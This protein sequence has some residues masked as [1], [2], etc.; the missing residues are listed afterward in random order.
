MLKC[1]VGKVEGWISTCGGTV[2]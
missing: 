1:L 2:V